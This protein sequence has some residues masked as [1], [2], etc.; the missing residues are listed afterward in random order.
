MS[1]QN[2]RGWAVVFS[3]R[4]PEQMRVHFSKAD[5]SRGNAKLKGHDLWGHSEEADNESRVCSCSDREDLAQ[6]T[7]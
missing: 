6:A 3:S 4:Q 2:I 7:V 5:V 1:G